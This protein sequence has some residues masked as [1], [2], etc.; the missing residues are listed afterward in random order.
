[1][2]H[3]AAFCAAVDAC[4]TARQ[5]TFRRQGTK[6]FLG[7]PPN[8]GSLVT[9]AQRCFHAH[10]ATWAALVTQHFS[11]LL[12]QPLSEL[13]P[14]DTISAT[15]ALRVRVVAEDWVSETRRPATVSRPFADGLVAA[16]FIDLP[17]SVASV[18][19][20]DLG[21]WGID[22]YEAFDAAYQNVQRNEPISIDEV[23]LGDG[24]K[25]HALCSDSF[26]CATHVVWLD[27]LLDDISQ[28]GALVI[29]PHRHAVIV[30]RLTRAPMAMAAVRRLAD[31]ARSMHL[32]GPGS[33]TPNLYWWR[34]GT[35]T[36]LPVSWSGQKVMLSAPEEFDQLLDALPR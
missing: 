3:W 33:L 27:D 20:S 8:E 22:V 7:E 25:V 19:P 1:M 34:P 30:H 16:L 9:L 36:H 6:L 13:L 15:E 17:E 11:A 5:T 35:L 21:R 14:V 18:S 31:L 26:F 4:L 32:Q 23:D 2:T 10:P 12:D 28:Y 24:V 29:I